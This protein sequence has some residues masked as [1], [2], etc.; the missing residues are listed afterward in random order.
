RRVLGLRRDVAHLGV[1]RRAAVAAD[2]DRL[3][4]RHAGE[5]GLRDVEARLDVARRQDRRHRP[6]RGHPLARDEERVLH[7]SRDRRGD[8]LLLEAPGGLRERGFRRRHLGLGGLALG[9]AA[10]R[11]ARVAELRL[12]LLDARA[13]ADVGAARLVELRARGVAFLHQV[14]LARELH[15][16]ELLGGARLVDLLA[17]RGDLR[18]PARRLQVLG[19]RLRALQALLGLGT[20]RALGFLLEREYRL[21][22]LDLLAATH[23]ELLQL[24]G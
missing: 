18:R 9:L 5:R 17:Q 7:Q 19:A 22:G 11:H 16:R 14:F 8:A 13:V 12:G 4:H 2:R 23:V 6:A 10:E 1:D 21:A 3:A 15:A 20:R 24:A